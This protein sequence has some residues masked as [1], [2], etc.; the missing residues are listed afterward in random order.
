MARERA[1]ERGRALLE[2]LREGSV[3]DTYNMGDDSSSLPTVM[4][5]PELESELGREDEEFSD[6]EGV[7]IATIRP[8][9]S[10]KEDKGKEREHDAEEEE[11]EAKVATPEPETATS[12]NTSSP[13]NPWFTKESKKVW[14][15]E[16]EFRKVEKE[17]AVERKRR[18]E[19]MRCKEEERKSGKEEKKRKEEEESKKMPEKMPEE[20]AKPDEETEEYGDFNGRGGVQLGEIS[21][22]ED[23]EQK[24]EEKKDELAV[25]KWWEKPEEDIPLSQPPQP[26]GD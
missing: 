17:E 6:D 11:E 3:P 14:M 22:E 10:E 8:T 18:E 12:T 5:E 2:E 7:E 13:S 20:L 25:D 9:Q 24:E 23:K 16:K 4:E 15:T 26:W 1:R 19:E 21:K